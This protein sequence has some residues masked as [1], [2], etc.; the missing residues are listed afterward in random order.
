MVSWYWINGNFWIIR[1]WYLLIYNI[2]CMALAPQSLLAPMAAVT[3]VFNT[4]LSYFILHE[5]ITK[6]D[7]VGI[8]IIATGAVTAIVFGSRDE[9]DVYINIIL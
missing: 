2:V 9:P 4:I 8:A 7:V 3:L 5:D 6:M 1:Y